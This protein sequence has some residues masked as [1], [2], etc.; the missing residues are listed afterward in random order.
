MHGVRSNRSL[1]AGG[2]LLAILCSVFLFP[3]P[4]LAA[5]GMPADPPGQNYPFFP[6]GSNAARGE[7]LPSAY[8]PLLVNCYTTPAGIYGYVTKAGLPAS[9]ITINIILRDQSGDHP[10]I[11]TSVTNTCG[12]YS[13]PDI[14]TINQGAGKGYFVEFYNRDN[15]PDSL[16]QWRTQIIQTYTR[17]QVFNIG[18]FDISDV[19][20]GEPNSGEAKFLP[21]TFY[22]TKRSYA[23]SDSYIFYIYEF[24]PGN[25]NI[26]NVKY[27]TDLLGFI[28]TYQLFKSNLPADIVSEKQY[29]WY[30]T[31]QGPN[32]ATG[33]AST[34]H[35]VAFLIP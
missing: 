11:I 13:F 28:D 32:G 17:F 7:L 14:P 22:W 29:Y 12:Y 33:R 24:I 20:L 23:P 25:P 5:P 9:G 35:G 4:G 21:V 8:L 27:Y 16:L 10:L 34:M 30:L 26:Y 18:N 3:S 2:L 15:L 19:T 1:V 6:P 31:I